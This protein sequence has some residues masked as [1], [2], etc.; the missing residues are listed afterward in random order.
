MSI[1]SQRARERAIL[2][3]DIMASDAATDIH[4][5]S[6]CGLS[7]IAARLG[8]DA[9]DVTANPA[10]YLA[11]AAWCAVGGVTVQSYGDMAGL[12]RDGWCP[13]EPVIDL[14]EHS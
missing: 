5:E 6:W 13:G 8:I 7:Q 4:E 12:L 14:K 9:S 2:I 11:R 3:L 10:L 1:Y